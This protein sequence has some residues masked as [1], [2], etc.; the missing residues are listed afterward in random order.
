MKYFYL[1]SGSVLSK[2][3][4]QRF[5]EESYLPNNRRLTDYTEHVTRKSHLDYY[6]S[7]V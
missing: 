4:F 6:I 1:I 2:I 5:P 7:C 3:S